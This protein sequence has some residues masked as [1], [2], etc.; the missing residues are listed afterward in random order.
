MSNNNNGSNGK[1]GR[2]N[3]QYPRGARGIPKTISLFRK[4]KHMQRWFMQ[5]PWMKPMLCFNL[6]VIKMQALVRRFIVRNLGAKQWR[7]KIYKKKKVQPTQLNCYLANLDYYTRSKKTKPAYLDDGYSTWCAVRIQA[8]WRMI[9]V[10]RHHIFRIKDIY[11]IGAIQ[12]QNTWRQKHEPSRPV[13][14]ASAAKISNNGANLPRTRA[15]HARAIQ[16]AWRTHCSIRVFRYF[17]DLVLNKLKGAP[18]DLLRCIIPAEADILDKASG[19]HVRF[20]LGGHIFPPK[21]YYKIYTHRPLCDLNSFA[22]RHYANESLVAPTSLH[23]KAQKR[24]QPDFKGMKEK[25]SMTSTHMRVGGALFD[26]T[27]DTSGGTKDWYKREDHNFWRPISHEAT[28]DPMFETPYKS[29]SRSESTFNSKKMKKAHYHFSRFKRQE[30]VLREKKKKKRD[31]MLKAYLFSAGQKGDN[32]E[33]SEY[34][35]RCEETP[36]S[37]RHQPNFS[38][39]EE[40]KLDPSER[41]GSQHQGG[42]EANSLPPGARELLLSDSFSEGTSERGEGQHVGLGVGARVGDY[43]AR[44]RTSDVMEDE[45]LLKWSLALDYEVYNSNWASMAVSMPSDYTYANVYNIG[46]NPATKSIHVVI[47]H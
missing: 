6:A 35:A 37:C 40:E 8:W 18:M 20:R 32:I 29:M 24:D 28:D 2:R 27:V 4:S 22:P 41:D 7:K 23:L 15:E 13:T 21:I 36:V 31:W 11:Q 14:T 47:D 9:P 38:P 46:N 1:K 19:V 30:D 44:V 43:H 25:F 12:I 10:R 17:K 5:N 33:D 16:Y 42:E 34:Y 45:D 26:A 39:R 3:R